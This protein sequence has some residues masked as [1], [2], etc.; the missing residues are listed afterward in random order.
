ME[1]FWLSLSLAGLPTVKVGFR[2]W[3]TRSYVHMKLLMGRQLLQ[4]ERLFLYILA[5]DLDH[6]TTLEDIS[7][8]AVTR[9]PLLKHK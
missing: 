5:M 4:N 1:S 6:Q 2:W 8:M 3:T 9:Q 7:P